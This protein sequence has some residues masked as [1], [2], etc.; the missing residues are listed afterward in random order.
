MKTVR[1]T[2]KSSFQISHKTGILTI[3][4]PVFDLMDTQLEH[5]FC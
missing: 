2:L 5:L 4:T 3:N 1:S